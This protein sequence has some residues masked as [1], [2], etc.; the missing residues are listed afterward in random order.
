M[1]TANSDT[2]YLKRQ[3]QTW[4]FA[5]AIP[6]PLRGRFVSQGRNGKPGRPLTRIVES[7]GTQSLKEAQEKRWPLVHEWREKFKRANAGVPLTLAEIDALARECYSA[8]LASLDSMAKRSGNPAKFNHD[9][10]QRVAVLATGLA[11][12]RR[13]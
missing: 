1:A 12:S 9:L 13:N 4:Y 3:F 2:R 8:E 7:L 11:D 5:M 6:R 10:S